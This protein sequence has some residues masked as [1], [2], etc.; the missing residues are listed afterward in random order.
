VTDESGDTVSGLAAERFVVYEDGVE[1][2]LSLFG[3]AD[4]PLDVV[5]VADAS[6]SMLQELPAVQDG[7][8][9]LLDRLGPGD[10][11]ALILVRSQVQTASPL[12]SDLGSVRSAISNIRADGSTALYD[13]IYISCLGLRRDAG[14]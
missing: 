9:A 2:Q 4:V 5:L 11:A 6:S 3:A 1:Q 14:R 8:Q 13:G 7:A 10:R 12:S